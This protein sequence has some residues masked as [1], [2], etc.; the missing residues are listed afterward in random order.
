MSTPI[1]SAAAPQNLVL[2]PRPI[3]RSPSTPLCSIYARIVPP[4]TAFE[5]VV[6]LLSPQA[7]PTDSS[8]MQ[9]YEA[10][11]LQLSPSDLAGISSPSS[12]SSSR[13]SST[14]LFEYP[15]GPSS[16]SPS[17]SISSPSTPR[18]SRRMNPPLNLEKGTP[19]PSH[20]ASLRMLLISPAQ[21]LKKLQKT[22]AQDKKNLNILKDEYAEKFNPD[23]KD[24]NDELIKAMEL[25]EIKIKKDCDY[26]MIPVTQ[27]IFQAVIISPRSSPPTS[28]IS[29][30][31]PNPELPNLPAAFV[32]PPAPSGLHCREASEYAKPK[33]ML[34]SLR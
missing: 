28:P 29:P 12:S 8:I 27:E 33:K 17:S 20:I 22:I 16:T 10:T 19:L 32:L 15:S 23:L 34:G 2:I 21:D 30:P 26:L 31:D 24:Q 9:V 7:S 6:A 1:D 25:L 4:L 14:Q 13:S 11:K 3:S 18:S 5:P